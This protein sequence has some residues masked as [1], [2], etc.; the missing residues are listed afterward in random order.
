MACHCASYNAFTFSPTREFITT[1]TTNHIM[2]KTSSTTT[3]CRPFLLSITNA[4]PSYNTLVSEAVRLLVPSARFEASKLKVV[5]LEDQINK[6]ASII[7][8]TYILSHCDFTANLTLAV[9]NVI[10]LEQLRGWYEKDDV[11]AE[12]KKVQND[13]CLHVHCFVSGPNSFLDLAAE[14]RYH[15]FSKEM[16]L[17]LKAIH[18]GDSALF[19]EHPELLDSIVRVYFHSCSEK[20]NRM[21]CW[22]PLKDAMEGKQA[23]QFQGSIRRDSPEKL[24]SPKSIF[25]ALFAFLL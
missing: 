22:G 11:V 21:E 16:P 6:H 20:Y 5:L 10:N 7:P 8:R 15:I 14:L 18:C 24:R 4:T 23:D 13:M 17:V 2:S 9:S 19:R 12:W 1:T 3:R 25:Q